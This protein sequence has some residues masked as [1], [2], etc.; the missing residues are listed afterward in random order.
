MLWK[1]GKTVQREEGALCRLNYLG[2]GWGRGMAYGSMWVKSGIMFFEIVNK[3]RMLEYNK[4]LCSGNG[5]K[6]KFWDDL[7]WCIGVCN[8]KG[9]IRVK[10]R[11]EVKCE[12]KRRKEGKWGV[13]WGIYGGC[14]R[15]LYKRVYEGFAIPTIMCWSE[16]CTMNGFGRRKLEVWNEMFG[17]DVYLT[18]RWET[19]K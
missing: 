18:V 11:K 12:V 8:G 9:W 15:C 17:E 10:R 6:C 19:C 4:W 5:K 2:W 3:E 13:L 16:T 14:G 7:K 1:I